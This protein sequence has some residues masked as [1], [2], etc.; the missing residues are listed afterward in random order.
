MTRWL[1]HGILVAL[2]V[3]AISCSGGPKRVRVAG[4]VSYDGKSVDE[5]WITF[6]PA[7][8]SSKDEGAEIKGGHFAFTCTPG[9]KIVRVIGQRDIKGTSNPMRNGEPDK[10]EYIP[11]VYNTKST[12]SV[13]VPESDKDD[14]DFALE[15][16]RK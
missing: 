10:E 14:F 6:H 11:E 2:F 8:N 12:L 16:A 1:T 4:K 9:R 5:G 7:D 13:D 3:T 15:K